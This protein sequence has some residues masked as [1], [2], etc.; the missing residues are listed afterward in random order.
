VLG[1]A[2]GLWR[3]APL[4]DAD[5]RVLQDAQVPRLEQAR[6]QAVEWRIEADLHLGRHGQL[7]PEL[8]AL[9]GEYPLREHARAQLM[10]ALYRC[11]RQGEAL[12]A[13]QDARR[14]LVA[15]LGVEPA[16]ELRGLH[17]RILAADPALAS[18]AAGDSIGTAA[19]DG[20]R[21]GIVGAAGLA[22]GAVAPRQLPAAIAHFTGRASAMEAL[23]RLAAGAAGSVA[24]G[25]AVVIAAIVGAAGIGKTALAVQWG[26]Q[27]AGL[28]PSGQLYVNLRGFDPA[29]TPVEPGAAI[30]GFLETLGVPGGQVPAGL[31]AQAGLYRSLVAGRRMLIVLGNARDSEQVRPLLPGSAGCLV[32]V[33]SRSQLAGLVAV[34]GAH[35]VALDVLTAGEA[36]DLLSRRLGDGRVAAEPAA[37]GELA[38]LCARLPL[39]LNITAARAIARPGVPLAVLAEELRGDQ[40]RLAA[41]EGGD[42]MASVRA[43]FSGSLRE[44]DAAASLFRLAGLHPGPD[45]DRYAAAALTGSRPEQAAG[46][47]DLLARAHLVHAARPGRYGMHD[48]LRVYARELAAARDSDDG[49]D[50]QR[51]ALTRLFDH[52]LHAA[53]AAMDTLFPAERHRRPRIPPR[54]VPRFRRWLCLAR[55]GSG[56]MPSGPT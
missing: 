50:W 53:A 30:R 34:D 38:G 31:D 9:V 26:Q 3:G 13:Y 22:G 32:L 15:E 21:A 28:F 20:G 46:M 23:S 51:A 52:Y 48:L 42:A 49:E 24:A 10:L 2:L 16:A 37:A 41:L 5:S 27:N 29:G 54:R 33:T 43:V 56:W 11:G 8:T 36:D 18:P 17:R 47:L 4:A 39:A 6:L 25:G 1:E 45:L 40:G 35:P 19:G 12:A 55:R 44:L 7:V 14:V